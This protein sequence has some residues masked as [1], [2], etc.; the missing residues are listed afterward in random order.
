M[1]ADDYAAM[2]TERLLELFVETAKRT[3]SLF[4]GSP[5]KLERSPERLD[6]VA[7]IHALGAAIAV[8]KPIAEVRRLFEDDDRDVRAFAAGHFLGIDPEWAGATMS[9][10][11]AGL[12][13][14]EVLALCRRALQAPP[15]R[16]MLKEMPD[17][18][19]VARFE[20]AATRQYATQ[21]LDRV[22]DP[23]DMAAYN[24][25]AREVVHVIQELKSRGALAKLCPLLTNP[26]MT[27]RSRAA[28]ACLRIAGDKAVA[29][30][31]SVVA[32]GSFDERLAARDTL[33]DWHKGKC[34]VDGL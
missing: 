26:N 1:S 3:G 20:D 24:R 7:T 17:A 9:G 14:R 16:P 5:E 21:F 19:L 2:S 18:A 29:A 33:D 28:Q 23:E 12:P 25:I 8:R 22:G 34:L 31:E 6:G 13:T 11:F 10:L 27:V 15:S 4:C 30:L 32:S